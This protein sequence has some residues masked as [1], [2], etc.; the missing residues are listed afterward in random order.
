MSSDPFVR[1]RCRYAY[2]NVALILSLMGASIWSPAAQA[3][4]LQDGS[5]SVINCTGTTADGFIAEPDAEG[6]SVNVEADAVVQANTAENP[7]VAIQVNSGNT[8]TNNGLIENNGGTQPLNYGINLAGS[9]NLL[10]NN[11]TISLAISADD[12][13]NALPGIVIGTRALRGIITTAEDEPFENVQVINNGTVSVQHAGVGA[14]DGVFAGEDI[15]GLSVENSGII[16]TSRTLPL[17]VSVS[18]AGALQANT[19]AD[20][21]NR[22]L[23]VADAIGS[24]DDVDELSITNHAGATIQATGDYTAAIYARA[25][26]VEIANEGFIRNNSGAIAVSSHGEGTTEVENSGS[27]TGDILMVDGNA[28]RIWAREAQGLPGLTINQTGVRNSG[29]ENSGTITGNIF[30]GSGTHAIENEES[31]TILGS[32][33]VDQ[34]PTGAVQGDRQFTLVNEGTLT[35]SITIRDVAGAVNSVTLVGGGFSGSIE[36]TTGA[37]TNSLTVSG[38]GTLQNV[39][40]FTTLDVVAPPPEEGGGGGGT[41]DDDDDE[42]GGDEPAGTSFTLA[43]G[44]VQEFSGGT[45]IQSGTLIV[46]GALVSD[47][48]VFSGATLMGSGSIGGS[49]VNNGTI[50]LASQALTVTGAVNLGAGSVLKTTVFGS[51]GSSAAA[52]SANAGALLV[53]ATGTADASARVVP[54]LASGVAV[55]NGEWYR[56]ATNTSGGAVFGSLPQVEGDTALFRWLLQQNQTGDLALGVSIANAATIPGMPSANVGA[57]NTASFNATGNPRLLPLQAAVLALPTSAAVIRAGDQLRP[58]ANGGQIQVPIKN[59]DILTS[60]LDDRIATSNLSR[61]GAGGVATRASLQAPFRSTSSG[62][63]SGEKGTGRAVWLQGFGFVGDQDTVS[64]VAGYQATTGGVA[65]G[66]DTRVG[67]DDNALVG[68]AFSYAQSTVDDD[69]PNTGNSSDISSYLG[70][71]YGSYVWDN[72]YLNGA[73]VLGLNQY[74]TRR[75]LNTGGVVDSTSGSFDG[76]QYGA[77]VE[78]GYPVPYGSFTLV[79]IG[80]LYYTHLSQDGYTESSARGAALAI[81]SSDTDSFRTGLG[82]RALYALPTEKM[83]SSLELRAVWLHEFGDTAQITTARFA[84]GSSTFTTNGFQPGRDT[85]SLSFGAWFASLDGRQR[86]LI[87]YNLEL[88]SQYTGQTGILQARFDF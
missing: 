77:K 72:A 25:L 57:L 9:D 69:A 54:Q 49:V 27:I 86:V 64:G 19:S 40:K 15:D 11:G 42:G 28:L 83:S 16:Q 79:P 85:A 62:V 48:N 32:I 61:F 17:N 66:A 24:D 31:G 3:D 73:L 51:G 4:C 7:S 12:V 38:V 34:N 20:P 55:R 82:A 5:G 13:T 74:D 43:S 37:G 70:T 6:L 23:G 87:A 84:A 56:V 2:S 81:N 44:Y 21:T 8:L 53:G 22:T 10:T 45:N 59:S 75:V 41:D 1:G 76:W 36:A 88:G 14:A 65:I 52:P 26:E 39:L 35:G 29:I 80:A 60:V 67:S 30:L 47:V 33:L 78:A 63:S 58:E 18:G 71:V 68:A 50:D 46:D